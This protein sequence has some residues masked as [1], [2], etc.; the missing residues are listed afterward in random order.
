[1]KDITHTSAVTMKAQPYSSR[2]NRAGFDQTCF[3]CVTLWRG[4]NT[5]GH[6]HVI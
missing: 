2:L 6:T 4:R 5:L 1:M 3:V